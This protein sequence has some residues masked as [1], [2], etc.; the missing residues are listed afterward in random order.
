MSNEAGKAAG[1]PTVTTD[2]PASDALE[3]EPVRACG[4]NRVLDEG[5]CITCSDE[6]RPARV[7]HIN[8]E[9]G[10]A[11]VEIKDQTEEVDIN[12]VEEVMPGDWLLVHG[13]VAI[14]KVVTVENHPPIE[15]KDAER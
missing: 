13:G 5:H 10:T 1:I 6:A 7:L 14:A 4:D 3:F 12:L 11:L 2:I 8:Q 15:A 9:L